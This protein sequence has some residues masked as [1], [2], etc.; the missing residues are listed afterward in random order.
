MKKKN[1]KINA[2]IENLFVTLGL[3]LTVI[4]LFNG[5]KSI[6]DWNKG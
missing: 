2:T 6:S 1:K 3:L 5:F 4:K